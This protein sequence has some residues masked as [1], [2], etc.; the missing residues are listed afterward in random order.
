M[1]EPLHLRNVRVAVDDRL[2]VLEPRGET[3]LAGETSS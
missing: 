1:L 2:A 3:R